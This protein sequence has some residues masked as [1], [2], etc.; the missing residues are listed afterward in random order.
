MRHHR[1]SRRTPKPELLKAL[2]AALDALPATANGHA[3]G[4]ANG[5]ANGN[6]HASGVAVL[7]SALADTASLEAYLAPRHV[8]DV[9]LDATP[10]KLTIA[11]V[12]EGC[13]RR[14]A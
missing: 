12:R 8:L 10:A 6:G 13:W 4:A 11:Q 7:R 2:V 1:I 3:N 5:H 9:V 14:A